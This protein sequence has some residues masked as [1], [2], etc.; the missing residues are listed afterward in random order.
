VPDNFEGEM[1]KARRQANRRR[2][3]REM[4]RKADGRGASLPSANGPTSDSRGRRDERAGEGALPDF[5]VIGAQKCGTGFLYRHLKRHPEIKSTDVR[6]V[7]YFDDNYGKGLS[8]YRS[9]FPPSKGKGKRWTVT[10]E[11]SPYY[12]YHPH[13]AMRIA[14]VI[15]RAKLIVLLRNPVDRAYSA[16][17]HQVRAGH[18][19]LSFEEAIAA[20]EHRLRG[21]EGRMLADESY[22]SFDHRHF[23]YLSRG[24]YVDQLMTWHRFF[25]REQMLVL[26][27]ENFY[28][29]TQEALDLVL[30]FIGLPGHEF[31]LTKPKNM[32]SYEPMN[33]NTRRRLEEFFEPHNRRLYDYLGIDFNW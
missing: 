23:S 19:T 15:P 22:V 1:E 25:D 30:N 31:D 16:Y 7:H 21:E 20:E 3:E 4:N 32:N 9:Q 11:K 12:L 27:S 8:W 13:A 5:V 10:G 17:H 24:V 6:E 2:Q 18:E 33:P 28:E 26:K 29:H 14:E